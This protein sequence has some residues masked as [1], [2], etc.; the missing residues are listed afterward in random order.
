MQ[1]LIHFMQAL[2]DTNQLTYLFLFRFC[3]NISFHPLPFSWTIIFHMLDR[4][5]VI[6][7]TQV[8]MQLLRPRIHHLCCCMMK[9]F[10]GEK[11][12]PYVF[13]LRPIF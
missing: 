7:P 4:H 13:L 12:V 11:F 1:S 8:R 3:P 9:D 2:V 10:V 6:W 5:L